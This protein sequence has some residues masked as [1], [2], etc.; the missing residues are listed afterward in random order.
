MPSREISER[1]DPDPDTT[2]EAPARGQGGAIEH[3]IGLQRSIGNRRTAALVGGMQPRAVSRYKIL[4]PFNK[5]QA[6]HET[7]TLLAVKKA[8]ERLEAAKE[9]PGDL[10]KDFNAGAVPDVNKKFSYDPINADASHAQFVR[11]VVWADDPEGLLFDQE[12]DTSDYSSGL[13]WY[14]HFR[15]GEKGNF[16]TLTARSHFGDLQFFH[17]MASKDTEAPATTKQHMLEWGRF[18]VDVATG[19]ILTDSKI[20]DVPAIKA[21]FPGIPKHTIKQLFGFAKASDV[22]ARQR[23]VGA[24]FHM[25]QD[26]FAHGHVDRDAAGD[27]AEFH[28]YGGQDEDKHGEYDFLGGTDKEKLGERVAKTMGAPSAIDRCADVLTLIAEDKSTDEIIKFLDETVFK[29]ASSTKPAGPGAGLT[30]PPPAP[31][32]ERDPRRMDPGKI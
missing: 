15:D 5:G 25:I 23:A 17:G 1:A 9:A 14:S 10:L 26:S 20:E 8:K 32:K 28:A 13:T 2:R 18:L 29:L 3:L 16:S 31:V 19:R 30:K 4:G 12:E 7:L 24:L 21:M 22:Q 11:G 6:V 27:I